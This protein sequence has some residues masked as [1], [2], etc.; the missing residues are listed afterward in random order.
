VVGVRER[1]N[2]VALES[3]IANPA[4]PNMEFVIPLGEVYSEL[5]SGR[6]LSNTKDVL[7]KIKS[8]VELTEKELKAKGITI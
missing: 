3:N 6:M 5:T 4:V 8:L 7:A 1:I 2:K